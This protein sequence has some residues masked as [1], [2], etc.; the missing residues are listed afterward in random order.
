L[1]ED[2]PGALW[3]R[4]LIEEGRRQKADIPP[5]RRIVVALDPAVSV[6]ESSD[7]TGII[8]AG[9][10]VD[11]HGYLLEDAS[12]KFSPIE[13]ARRAVA[14]YRK[15]GAD[16]IVAEANQGGLLVETTVRTVD[17]NVSFKAVHASRG[18][19]TRAEP[20]AALAEQFRI[21]LVG[22]FPELEDRHCT[23]AAGSSDSPDRLDAMVWAFTE[24]MVESGA[25]LVFSPEF[26]AQF[27]AAS[28]SMRSKQTYPFN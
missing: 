28:A 21:H 8:V 25:P 13:W 26:V 7:E 22:S 5:M 4:D 11:N 15:W 20:I 24:L 1:L 16:R 2:T 6:S 12:G 9:L 27:A 14:L 18:K 17:T 23:Y 3:T 19:I 10:G